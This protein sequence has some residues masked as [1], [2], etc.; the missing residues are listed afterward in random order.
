MVKGEKRA[1]LLYEIANEI[2]LLARFRIVP[3]LEFNRSTFISG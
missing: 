3:P 1:E 2:Y